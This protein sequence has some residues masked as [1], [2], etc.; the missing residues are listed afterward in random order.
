MLLWAIGV[1]KIDLKVIKEEF[2]KA[3]QKL[4]RQGFLVR[5]APN[6]WWWKLGGECDHGDQ[7]AFGKACGE[8]KKA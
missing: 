2:S 1:H 3:R 5:K 6:N 4:P 7:M 8:L